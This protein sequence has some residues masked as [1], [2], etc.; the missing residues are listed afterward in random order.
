MFSLYKIIVSVWN[1]RLSCITTCLAVRRRSV[2]LELT[3]LSERAA[4]LVDE[5]DEVVGLER[6]PV[7]LQLVEG[8][9]RE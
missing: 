9:V 1:A 7:H 8:L 3:G 4:H 5:N 6:L 2:G